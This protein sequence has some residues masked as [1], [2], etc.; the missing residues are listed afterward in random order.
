M[1]FEAVI[2]GI[3]E[4]FVRC[5]APTA[6]KPMI[7]YPPPTSHPLASGWANLWSRLT[8]L[9]LLWTIN[10]VF[11]KR[12]FLG[13]NERLRTCGREGQICRRVVGGEMDR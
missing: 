9:G 4:L 12:L 11:T 3:V 8:A 13:A 5:A 6:L 10:T 7:A 2:Y 1:N